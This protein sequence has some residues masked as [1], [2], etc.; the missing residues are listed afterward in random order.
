MGGPTGGQ[1]G[2]GDFTIPAGP[3]PR[4]PSKNRSGADA[5]LFS[6][7]WPEDGDEHTTRKPMTLFRSYGLLLKRKAARAWF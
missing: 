1:A 6:D 2:N 5:P 3:L 4:Q 7:Q